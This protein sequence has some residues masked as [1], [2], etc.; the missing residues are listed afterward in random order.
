MMGTQK[1]SKTRLLAERKI[2]AIADVKALSDQLANAQAILTDLEIAERVLASLGGPDE[3]DLFQDSRQEKG[4][5]IQ[6]IKSI[7]ATAVEA[8]IA[9]YAVIRTKEAIRQV[10]PYGEQLRKSEIID[11]VQHLNPRVNATTV[12]VEL[13]RMSKEGELHSLGKGVY[14]KVPEDKK[15]RTALS[16]SQDD[17]LGL[18]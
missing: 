13:S 18:V 12:G 8:P 1:T 6:R 3:D 14:L 11:A 15:V 17:G 2:K 4:P 10:M 7:E 16:Q 5:L 9:T